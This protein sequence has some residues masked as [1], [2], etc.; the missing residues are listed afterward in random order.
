MIDRA[1]AYAGFLH[2]ADNL[3]KCRKVLKRIAIQLNIADMA[4]IC[5]SVVRGFDLNFCERTARI[6]YRNM[7]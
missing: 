1:I 4:G 6:V 5:K 2:A 3:F 7:E